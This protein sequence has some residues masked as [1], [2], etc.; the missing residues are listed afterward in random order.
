MKD[1]LKNV[2]IQNESMDTKS[3]VP[4]FQVH[5][6]KDFQR[7][8]YGEWEKLSNS[9]LNN[10]LDD[11]VN[12]LYKNII[13]KPI[14]FKD[15]ISDLHIQI[16]S[17]PGLYHNLKRNKLI[18]SNQWEIAQEIPLPLPEEFNKSL[19]EN[20][21]NGQNAISIALDDASAFG[22]NPEDSIKVKVGRNGISIFFSDDFE[23]TLKNIDAE[24][25]PIYIKTSTN[26]TSI[27]SVFLSYLLNNKINIKK[28]SGGFHYDPLSV[29][30]QKHEFPYDYELLFDEIVSL[31]T[32][33]HSK[34]CPFSVIT[35]NGNLFNESGGNAVQEIAFSMSETVLYLKELISRGIE[36]N[37]AAKR[38]RLSYSIGPN[39]F[40]EISKLRAARLLW[41]KIIK[42]FGGNEDSQKVFIHAE[43][44]KWNK[45]KH[46]PYVNILRN[47]GEALSAI[48][49]GC[50]SLNLQYFD[51]AF[52]IPN[53]FSRRIT[54]NTQLVLMEECDLTGITDIPGGSWYIENLTNELAKKAW[55]LF[56]EVE[57][58]GGFYKALDNGFIKEEIEK[59]KYE[60]L[61]NFNKKKDVLIGTNIYPNPNEK[62]IEATEIDYNAIF[63]QIHS[64]LRVH[65]EKRDNM[66]VSKL[67]D[68]LNDTVNDNP[69][70]SFES[71]L[72][73]VKAGAT[74][75]EIS[76]PFNIKFN[77]TIK[78]PIEKMKLSE[79]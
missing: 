10:K 29:L 49:G 30:A 33:L 67:L 20:L 70:N 35:I 65:I 66:K 46:D 64:T 22:F 59:V 27:A 7:T 36:I 42:H 77:A 11:Y 60:R 5:L 62:P 51:N 6:L 48:L 39:F 75:G 31:I 12:K 61:F 45:T 17:L 13:T 58:K 79:L 76:K 1:K 52:G 63:K 2:G 43:T 74:L 28:L 54:R 14:Y 32:W 26:L 56:Q 57:K 38:I 53:E 18:H 37:E 73:A 47:T 69:I 8:N 21:I 55:E 78:N 23:K 50:D 41:S 72:N 68:V 4:T 40:V 71:A 44:C 25:Y 3:C 34:K 24:Q 9:I 19:S 15:D 16:N